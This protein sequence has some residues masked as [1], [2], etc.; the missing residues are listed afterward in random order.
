MLQSDRAL[1]SPAQVPISQDTTNHKGTKNKDFSI[2]SSTIW[3]ILIYS[4]HAMC[5]G[6][7][8]QVPII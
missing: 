4:S 5:H 8:V 1:G 3:S 2:N 7:Y 6:G